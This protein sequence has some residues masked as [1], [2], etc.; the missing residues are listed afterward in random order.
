[1]DVAFVIRER[2]AE[3]GLEQR[4][5]ARAAQV[6]ESYVS[7]LLTGKKAPPAPSRTAIYDRMDRFLKLPHGELAKVAK[8]ARKEELK[9]ELGDSPEPL[10][11]QV[12]ELLL[13]KC[14]SRAARAII[15]G[16]PFGE[17]ERLAVQRLLHVAELGSDIF[18]LSPKQLASLDA[19]IDS[20]D[21]EL[22][23]FSVEI[24]LHRRVGLGK[25]RRF[26]FVEQD[27]ESQP[28]LAEFL[29]NRSLSGSASKQELAFLTG[30][31]FQ[32]RHPTA[33]YYYRELQNLRD[34]L[35]FEGK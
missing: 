7:Q 6:T 1:V 20:W 8:L 26:E 21:V 12:R 31:R 15:V 22:A 13:R 17:L 28:G 35:H 34:P 32:G 18:R 14:R 11:P 10:L 5:L 25:V 24:V 2:L 16:Q 27:T 9:R 4:D 23:T 3:L 30:L 29:T 33:L 19:L